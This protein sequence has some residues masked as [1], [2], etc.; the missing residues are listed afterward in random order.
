MDTVTVKTR[1]TAERPAPPQAA[2]VVSLYN[3]TKT[4]S[5]GGT[6]VTPLSD[7]TL[8]IHAGEFIALMGPSGSG[9]STLLNLT[10]GIDKPTAGRVIVFGED[11]TDWREDDLALWRTRAI[12]YV[13]QQ[14]NLM[15]VLTAYENV[16]LPLLLLPL[17]ST[18]RRE[19]VN[20]A[21]DIVGLADRAHHFPRQLSGGQEQRVA[22]ARALACDPQVILADE[23]TGNL[24]RES[25]ERVMGLFEELNRSFGKTIVM[26]TH[27]P[28]TARH[29]TKVLHLDKGKLLEQD[30]EDE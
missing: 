26:V 8:N 2:P 11:I 30:R 27:D 24:D 19:L 23:P 3:V 1:R 18:K 7:L 5:K 12:G 16:E 20:T 14:F 15:P 17:S 10:A 28:H 25:A 22:I 21:L 13:F 6:E 4:Y 29:A 9:K